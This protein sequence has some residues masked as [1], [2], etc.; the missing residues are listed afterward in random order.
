M[1]ESKPIAKEWTLVEVKRLLR[2]T[3]SKIRQFRQRAI[4]AEFE[5]E[6]AKLN[7]KKVYAVLQL[8]ASTNKETLGLSSADD[9]KAWVL[10]QPEIEEAEIAEIEAKSTALLAQ[11]DQTFYENLF[12]AVRKTANLMED[13]YQDQKRV[14]RMYQGQEER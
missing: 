1:S 9:R 10:T 4:K 2:D 11:S 7:T 5:L 12:S 3:P 8:K 14:E 13:E 6:K